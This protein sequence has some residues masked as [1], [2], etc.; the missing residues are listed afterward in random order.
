MCGATRCSLDRRLSRVDRVAICGLQTGSAGGREKRSRVSRDT[1]IP[2]HVLEGCLAAFKSVLPHFR[3]RLGG[4]TR[5]KSLYPSSLGTVY[6]PFGRSRFSGSAVRGLMD[7]TPV[8][9][10]GWRC[11]TVSRLHRKCGRTDFS[12]ARHRSCSHR[13]QKRSFQANQFRVSGQSFGTATLACTDALCLGTGRSPVWPFAV[14]GWSVSG[15]R[16]AVA[17]DERTGEVRPFHSSCEAGE[18]D[19]TIGGGVG[20]AK[21][22]GQGEHA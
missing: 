5:R 17:D 4:S 20:G 13:F 10:T 9:S 3:C 11:A 15:R 12:T 8:C 14:K 16:G 1:Q 22:R 18:Q 6:S 19:W 2:E 21:G 7:A